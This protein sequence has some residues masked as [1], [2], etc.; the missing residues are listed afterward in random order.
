[1]WK[2]MNF[3]PKN[4]HPATG[5]MFEKRQS[6]KN[7]QVER[8]LVVGTMESSLFNR[9]GKNCMG[10]PGKQTALYCSH[11]LIRNMRALKIC[12]PFFSFQ[13][14][15]LFPLLLSPLSPLSPLILSACY[16]C[17]QVSMCQ[18]RFSAKNC[19]LFVNDRCLSVM[20]IVSL[21]MSICPE[22]ESSVILP[23][24]FIQL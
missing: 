16:S 14:H 7:K 17:R 24:S 20:S 5:W 11:I 2:K 18:R 9:K 10:C 12:H 22:K 4:K 6:K 8:E 19:V 21:S 15:F 1:M 13:T 23:L 3:V